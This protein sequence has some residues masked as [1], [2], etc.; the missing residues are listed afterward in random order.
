MLL[1]TKKIKT[2][3]KN[4]LNSSPL[5]GEDKGEGFKKLLKTKKSKPK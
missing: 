2:K 4:H 1:K 3:M 5:A